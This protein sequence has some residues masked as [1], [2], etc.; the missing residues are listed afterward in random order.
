MGE[1]QHEA[2]QFAF[3]GFLKVAFQ[4]SRVTSD[5]GL[6]LVRE[7]DERLGLEALISEHLSDS[8]QGLNTQFSLAD[9]LR[10]L[11]Y[12]GLAG[13]EDL[14]DA[15]RVSAD[16]T[17]RLIGSS[18]IW[19]R[20]TA[21]TSTL[22]WFE[23]ELLTR[24]ENLVGLMAV[25]REVLAQA[26]MPTRAGRI[27]LDMDSSESPVHGRRKGAPTTGTSSPSATTRCFCS[28][29]TGT[30]WPR[31]CDPA[32]CRAPTTGTT[33]S[34]RR[35]NGSKRRAIG[36]RSARTRRSPSRRST[37]KRPSSRPQR[38]LHSRLRPVG[39]NVIVELRKGH[40]HALH[41]LPCRRVVDRLCHRPEGDAELLEEHAQ[42]DVVMAITGKPAQVVDDQEL[43]TTSVLSTETQKA[44]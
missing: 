17:F 16:P 30:A 44:L 35:L 12:S 40:Q 27:V 2:F 33:C 3:N 10:E 9:L 4:G 1:L 23:T 24:E 22:H 5:A 13:Y 6:L 36:W 11:V 25:N 20:G 32:T 26:G 37:L 39:S 38:R 28:L 29:S 43:H 31:R 42:H 18:K 21:L 41:E 8:R 14:N 7:L 15:V 34:C 19:D